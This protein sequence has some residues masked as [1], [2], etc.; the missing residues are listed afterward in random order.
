MSNLSNVLLYALLPFVGNVIGV[1][2]A[3]NLKAPRWVT[4]AA[5]HAAAG[6]AIALVSVDLLPR[7]LDELPMSSI[8]AGFLIGA[9][10]S[11]AVA[12][13]VAHLQNLRILAGHHTAWLVFAA[14]AADLISDGLMTGAGTAIGSSLGFLVAA[15]QSVANIPGG[16]AVAASLRE[17][18]VPLRTRIGVT[19]TMLV[20]ILMSALIGAWL[21]N[22]AS[23]EVQNV[24]LCII[25]G[26]LL[27]ATVED[28]LPQGDKP[29]PQ[30]W[31]S[32]SAFAL[33][34]AGFALLAAGI[35]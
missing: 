12:Q 9:V 33:G 4:G 11:V 14:I 21:L 13:F 5:L 17:T 30:R 25:A 15:S 26:V 29:E 7:V 27:L 6:I 31:I 20:P 2:L 22:G 19:A 35:R 3:E 28:V 8:A 34:F 24:T 1:A 18:G 10:A 32:T 16:Y 23:G